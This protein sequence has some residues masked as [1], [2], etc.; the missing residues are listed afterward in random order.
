MPDLFQRLRR[1]LDRDE[2][3]LIAAPPSGMQRP[4]PLPSPPAPAAVRPDDGVDYKAQAESL[5]RQVTA[6]DK[7]IAELQARLDAAQPTD[8]AL[9]PLPVD[10]IGRIDAALD[11]NL[12][13]TNQRLRANLRAAEAMIALRD[14]VSVDELTVPWPKQ[15]PARTAT[16]A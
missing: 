12:R 5:L 3:V 9:V 6:K 1:N 11:E 2:R 4:E 16:R 14:G 13:E 15:T 7:H 8:A 10:A